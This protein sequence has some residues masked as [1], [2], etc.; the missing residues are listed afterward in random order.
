[1]GEPDEA[2][3]DRGILDIMQDH[4]MPLCNVVFDMRIK[5]MR[6]DTTR[7][8]DTNRILAEDLEQ[9]RS[10][11]PAWPDTAK[12]IRTE[13]QSAHVRDYLYTVLGL[14]PQYERKEHKLTAGKDALRDLKD[15][16]LEDHKKVNKLTEQE[17]DH[18]IKFIDSL[19]ELKVNDRSRD[20][21]LGQIQQVVFQITGLPDETVLHF[22]NFRLTGRFQG[23][24]QKLL[25]ASNFNFKV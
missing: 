24:P 15:M 23:T 17:K 10:N 20:I 22:D 21:D 8:G 13:N 9:G 18:A 12:G 2:M 19:A 5:G 16:L 7:M 1:M 25:F 14:P 11:L 3:V 4:I 6:L